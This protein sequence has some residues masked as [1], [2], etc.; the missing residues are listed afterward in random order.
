V[1]RLIHSTL[2]SCYLSTGGDRMIKISADEIKY[3]PNG[4]NDVYMVPDPNIQLPELEPM[5]LGDTTIGMKVNGSKLSQYLNALA[6][7]DRAM[8]GPRMQQ[9]FMARVLVMFFFAHVGMRPI[10]AAYGEQDSGKTSLLE[11]IG[12]LFYGVDWRA[13]SLP[14]KIR[15]M[16]AKL[17]NNELAF[18]NNTD[19]VDLEEQGYLNLFCN[20]AFGEADES[21][22]QLYKDNVELSWRISTNIGLAS[23][24]MNFNRSDVMRRTLVFALKKPPKARQLTK[25]ERRQMFIEDHSELLHELL[26]RVQHVLVALKATEGRRYNRVSDMDEMEMFMLRVA[27]YEGWLDECRE[28]W[29]A[30]QADY[31][32][33]I[34]VG[35]PLAQLLDLWIG[36]AGPGRE[37]TTTTLWQ[38]SERIF[39]RLNIPMTYKA[40]AVLGRHLGKGG[41]ATVLAQ[42]GYRFIGNS[43]SLHVFNPK[44]EMAARCKRAFR[45]A[46]VAATGEIGY[47]A[48]KVG[49]AEDVEE[50]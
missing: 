4:T 26:S 5:L 40:P 12:R 8:S 23:R 45:D 34:A 35:D 47:P 37:V 49:V 50:V 44:P 18:F 11:N 39:K 32:E 14:N 22:A 20:A 31:K 13:V 30:Y 46:M 2:D 3:V 38:E 10:I 43:H 1:H 28:I 33:D 25:P 7:D 17:T 15:D 21:A 6:W 41:K 48:D 27:D 42:Y 29:M 36:S 16:V 24:D 19:N 9:L